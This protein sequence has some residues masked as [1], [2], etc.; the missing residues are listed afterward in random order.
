MNLEIIT[1]E[2]E[3]PDPSEIINYEI[4]T[5]E[6]QNK[7]YEDNLEWNKTQK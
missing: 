7:Q 2:D 1:E 3:P 5:N 6:Y 4:K